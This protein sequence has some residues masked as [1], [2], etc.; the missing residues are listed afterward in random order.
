MRIKN[1]AVFALLVTAPLLATPKCKMGIA[2][3][4]LPK[5]LAV[6]AVGKGSP[7]EKAGL[8][9][10]DIII[11][12]DTF[13]TP[14]G[15]GLSIYISSMSGTMMKGCG[16]SCKLAVN[17]NG[18]KMDVD[19]FL[20]EYIDPLDESPYFSKETTIDVPGLI[21][22]VDSSTLDGAI[23]ESKNMKKPSGPRLYDYTNFK[24]EGARGMMSE[25][26]LGTKVKKPEVRLYF[27]TPKTVLQDD[28]F[29]RISTFE[30]LDK[31]ALLASH[32]K[33]NMIRVIPDVT[34][35]V[36]RTISG[37]VGS[38]MAQQNTAIIRVVI[39][40]GEKIIRPVGQNTE[41]FWFPMNAIPAD[42]PVDLIV[43]DFEGAQ[44][45][46]EITAKRLRSKGIA[47]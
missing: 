10:G 17:R 6:V 39:K 16:S 34:G 42:R 29:K 14:S 13:S 25:L 11:G 38:R 44:A 18:T 21:K 30:D 31:S 3:A 22:P 5:A 47:D 27:A 45:I 36:E 41:G 35:D 40:D 33:M 1:V 8:K 4:P 24:G 7:A 32:G 9:V 26:F 28:V 2:F 43:V 15:P 23:T 19:V 12:A 20:E 37:A 46:F